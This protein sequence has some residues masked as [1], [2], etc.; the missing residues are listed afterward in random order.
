MVEKARHDI[1]HSLEVVLHLSQLRH[2]AYR[3]CLSR[4]LLDCRVL[5]LGQYS[6]VP[7]HKPVAGSVCQLTST[8]MKTLCFWIA[9]QYHPIEMTWSVKS[10]YLFIANGKHAS[11]FLVVLSEG[12]EL[13]DSVSL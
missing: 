11:R 1:T 4:S 3:L 13:F 10:T 8:I 9:C 12:L 7:C 6:N 5:H 2:D